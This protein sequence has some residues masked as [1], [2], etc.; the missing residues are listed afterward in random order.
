MNHGQGV[1]V[2]LLGSWNRDPEEAG[3]SFHL[4]PELM[5]QAKGKCSAL[6]NKLEESEKNCGL[7]GMLPFNTNAGVSALHAKERFGAGWS[8]TSRRC[9]R[10]ELLSRPCM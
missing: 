4:K 7:L 8:W 1:G 3:A 9:R 5:P 10:R 6:M 2:Q